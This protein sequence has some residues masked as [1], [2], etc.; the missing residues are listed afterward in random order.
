LLIGSF[1]VGEN[2]SHRFA[3][4]IGYGFH[5]SIGLLLLLLT[6]LRVGW[7]LSHKT[8]AYPVTMSTVE[9]WAASLVKLAFYFLMGGHSTFRDCGAWG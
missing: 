1:L 6:F 5:V 7:R 8:P 4:G 2:T 3:D 9:K